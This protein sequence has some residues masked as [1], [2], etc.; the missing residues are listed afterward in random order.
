VQELH[1]HAT[2]DMTMRYAHLSPSVKREAV[3]LLD[4][5][6]AAVGTRRAPSTQKNEKAPRFG[7]LDGAGKGI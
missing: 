7:A 5:G 4:A 3:E 6:P 1:G 2:L